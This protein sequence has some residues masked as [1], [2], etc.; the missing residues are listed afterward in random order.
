M[1][2]QGLSCVKVLWVIELEALNLI[3]SSALVKQNLTSDPS[4]G[5]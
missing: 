1:C 3:D 5:I 4:K 2:E